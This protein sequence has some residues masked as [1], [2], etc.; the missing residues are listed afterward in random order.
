MRKF[1]FPMRTTKT[2]A[3]ANKQGYSKLLYTCLRTQLTNELNQKLTKAF[4]EDARYGTFTRGEK[5][6]R[7]NLGVKE[8]GGRLLKGGVF[9]GTYG[10]SKFQG[11][12]QPQKGLAAFPG[13]QRTRLRTVYK[14]RVT[15]CERKLEPGKT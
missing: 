7:K 10:N 9:S 15:T 12:D 1:V 2:L 11:L 4:P 6:L 3:V 13:L 8:G 14:T 5:H